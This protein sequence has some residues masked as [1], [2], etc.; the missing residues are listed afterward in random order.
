MG[1]LLFYTINCCIESKMSGTVS[2][3]SLTYRNALHMLISARP[4]LVK[5]CLSV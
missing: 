1:S 5:L 2:R 3:D 4:F